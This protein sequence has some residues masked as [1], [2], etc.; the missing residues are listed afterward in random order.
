MRNENGEIIVDNTEMQMI[1]RLLWATIHQ[2]NGGRNG[3]ILRKA[4]PSK[5]QS[6]RNRKF[7]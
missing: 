4:L 1:L 2:Y 7:Q 6:E 5:T 3:K